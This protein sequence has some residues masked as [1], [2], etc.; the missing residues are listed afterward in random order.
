M[1]PVSSDFLSLGLYVRTAVSLADIHVVPCLGEGTV[2]V[3]GHDGLLR[4]TQVFIVPALS[5]R[6]LFVASIYENSGHVEWG[7]ET[8][9]LFGRDPW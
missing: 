9:Q 3:K 4:I 1:S 2:P 5:M 8:T 7:E 6:L